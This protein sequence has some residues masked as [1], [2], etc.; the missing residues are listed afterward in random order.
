MAEEPGGIPAGQAPL[1][2]TAPLPW[3]ERDWGRLAAAL[4]AGRLGHALLFAGPPG[5]GKRLLAGLLGRALLCEN[6]GPTHL[7]CGA[8][9]G[10]I[11]VAAATHPDLAILTPQE[12][13]RPIRVQAVR[14]FVYRLTLS[15]HYGG[16]R[17]GLIDPAEGLTVAAANSLLKGLEEPPAGS[18]ILLLSDRP[19][20]VLPTIASRCQRLRLALPPAAAARQWL[21]G[22]APEAQPALAAARGA[23]LRALLLAQAGLADNQAAWLAAL[24]ALIGGRP[25]P[26][27]LALRWRADGAALALDWL[28]VLV[29]DV[30][31]AQQG[32]PPAALVFGQ[33]ESAR[34]AVAALAAGL[35]PQRLRRWIPALARTRRRLA[36]NVDVQLTLEALCIG[37]LG[38]RAR[39]KLSW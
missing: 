36:G 33:D 25:D 29:A 30:V 3:Q 27:A 12:P 16:A 10:C 22:I 23:P 24:Q 35:D 8:C 1:S 17:V 7:P 19:G 4:D 38:C 11:Q 20:Q 34:A 21:A 28:F 13:G 5:I 31:K 14:D 37:L 26:V 32:A 39:S 18:H 15:T 2:I 6:P 9:R